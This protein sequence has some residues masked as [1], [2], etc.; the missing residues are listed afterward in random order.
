ML[1]KCSKVLGT[2][3]ICLAAN[4]F[5]VIIILK[6]APIIDINHA[7]Y[8]AVFGDRYNSSNSSGLSSFSWGQVLFV[9]MGCAEYRLLTTEET[10]GTYMHELGHNLDLHH[11]G[12]DDTNYKPNYLSVMN[13][14]FQFDGLNVAHGFDTSKYDYSHYELPTLDEN[15]LI[16]SDGFDKDGLTAGTGLE[17]Y[18]KCDERRFG[19]INCKGYDFNK[20]NIIETSSVERNLNSNDKNLEI[21]NGYNDW[22][23]LI[24]RAG[25]IGNRFNNC[26]GLTLQSVESK[27]LPDELSYD[28]Y[29]KAL[30]KN[31][32]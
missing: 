3:Y 15:N 31:S 27:P 20:N 10:A 29:L 23:H 30:P 19:P 1:E 28:E 4:V 6:Y 13:Y 25:K 14:S 21:L 32:N 7:Y 5:A 9:A 11:G 22:E 17:T 18:V 12:G 24:Y 26:I 16:E 8:C 2:K